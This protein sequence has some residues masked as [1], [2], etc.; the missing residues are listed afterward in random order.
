M[1]A[2]GWCHGAIQLRPTYVAAT[3]GL[4]V[5]VLP[6]RDEKSAIYGVVNQAKCYVGFANPDAARN[7]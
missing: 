5:S 4:E 7:L 3:L 1:E 2:R 6:R